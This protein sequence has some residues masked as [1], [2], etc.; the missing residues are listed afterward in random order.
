[1]MPSAEVRGNYV[2]KRTLFAES[3]TPQ[4]WTSQRESK[5]TKVAGG[6]GQ[7]NKSHCCET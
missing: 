7:E 2:P 1:M 5:E 6:W 3:A 4:R